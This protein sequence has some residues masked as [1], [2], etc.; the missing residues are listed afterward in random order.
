MKTSKLYSIPFLVAAIIICC[1]ILPGCNFSRGV[2]TDLITGLK[3]SYKGFSVRDAILVDTGG[4]KLN[5]NKVQLNTKIAIAV[6]GVEN[7]GLKDGKTYPG[8]SL[9]VTD[10]NGKSMLNAADFFESSEG[11]PPAQASEL[12]GTITV[13][14]P[15]ISGQT[16][17]VKVRI[18]DK[19]TPTNEINAEV[20]LVVL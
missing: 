13:G 1:I 17:H 9:L 6:I 2:K 19:V 15:M 14:R 12:R 8:L 4:N 20:D 11:Y 5:S 18:W 3:L 10:K 16:Y 7:Y